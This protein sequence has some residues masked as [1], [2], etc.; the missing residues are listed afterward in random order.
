MRLSIGDLWRG[1]LNEYEKEDEQKRL[2]NLLEEEINRANET[3][4]YELFFYEHGEEYGEIVVHSSNTDDEF[5][6]RFDALD[7]VICDEYLLAEKRDEIVN[8][9]DGETGNDGKT[10][11][12]IFDY[13]TD[14]GDKLDKIMEKIK[15]LNSVDDIAELYN[16]VID[17][18]VI[19][20]P[21]HDVSSRD[22][23]FNEYVESATK[24]IKD[25]RFHIE[26]FIVS[27]Q[28]AQG[29]GEK[30]AIGILGGV[31]I[32]LMQL[33]FPEGVT[34][35]GA[36]AVD[37]FSIL[38]STII[39]FLF[40]TI[41]DLE[42]DRQAPIYDANRSLVIRK[43]PPPIWQKWNFGICLFMVI[44]YTVLLWDKQMNL[45]A[46]LH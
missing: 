20:L 22:D 11:N 37:L 9:I 3:R 24:E 21:R 23:K 33:G 15:N 39:V 36:L 19:D 46:F 42:R 13:A 43:P 25:L 26:K 29:S 28:H 2:D 44:V 1:D 8:I 5:I 30:I 18:K 16:K 34:G 35:A 41:F 38:T 17:L 7:L 27:K 4:K 32:A 45:L 31:L 6:N 12:E 14:K 40:C 10:G